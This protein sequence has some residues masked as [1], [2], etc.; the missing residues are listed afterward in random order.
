M[1]DMENDIGTAIMR[2]RAAFARHRVPAPDFLEYEDA[3]KAEQAR[4]ML[5]HALGP[6]HWTMN[7]QAS[8]FGEICFS[9]MTLRFEP[10]IMDRGNG[11]ELDDG[12]EGRVFYDGPLIGRTR[13]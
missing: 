5:R 4:Q 2:L 7:Q 6:T 8:P 11:P 9:G 3:E 13:P 1:N 10:K 12:I